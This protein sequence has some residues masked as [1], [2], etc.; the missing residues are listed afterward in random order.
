MVFGACFDEKFNVIHGIVDTKIELS[1]FRGAKYVQSKINDTYKEAKLYLDEG[2]AILFTGTP[3]QI[4]GL[5][6]YLK[7]DYDNLIC[8]DI[9]CH[10]VPSPKVWHKYKN[11]IIKEKDLIDIRFRDKRNGWKEY[12]LVFKFKNNSEYIELG[13][14]SKY[15]KGFI[16]DIYLR[17][18]CYN[19]SDKSINRES[20]ITLADFWGI[21]NI[22]PDMD[23]NKGTSLLFINT[24]KGKDILDSIKNEIIYKEVDIN[25]AI[26]YNT[27]AIKSVKK[28]LNR[29]E[30]MMR[31]EDWSFTKLMKKYCEDNIFIKCKLFI[32]RVL[33]KIKRIILR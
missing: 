5:K 31:L 6:S 12:S 25:E 18:S 7:K 15:I 10:G 8:Q 23:D 14:K 26:K 32:Y 3:C 13:S 28:P 4:S 20:D 19:C 17:P 30:F 11:S 9:I 27:S 24:N 33:S 2:R 1:K 29:D 16:K 22:L 21:Q